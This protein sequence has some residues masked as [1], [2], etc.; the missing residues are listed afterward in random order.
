MGK[1]MFKGVPVEHAAICIDGAYTNPYRAIIEVIFRDYGPLDQPDMML[2]VEENYEHFLEACAKVH[3]LWL[4][5]H[6]PC[7]VTRIH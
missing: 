4:E 1:L 2:F 3:D 5:Q 7:T 6:E